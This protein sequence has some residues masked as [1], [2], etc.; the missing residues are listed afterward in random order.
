MTSHH[1]R[2][3][4]LSTMVLALA[5]V[6][7]ACTSSNGDATSADQVGS[8]DAE[9]A[10]AF[11]V[12]IESGET[13][14]LDEHLAN[15]GRPVFLNLWAA[16]CFPCREEMPAIDEA[17]RAHPDVLFIG[18]DVQDSRSAA[19]TFLDEIGISYLIGFDDDSVVDNEYHPL[20]LPASYI[21]SSE[22][23]IL[24]RIFGVVTEEVLADKFATH[25]G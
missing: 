2:L 17:S 1:P 11:A 16:W 12:P 5:V 10:P 15:D 6:A 4:F 7:S 8:A 3:T 9:L 18:V 25:F 22:G 13:F 20:G 14:S 24:E 19:E 23:V 21:I